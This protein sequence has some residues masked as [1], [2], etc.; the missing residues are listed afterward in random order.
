MLDFEMETFHQLSQFSWVETE[1]LSQ[2]HL[3]SVLLTFLKQLKGKKRNDV[4]LKK[5]F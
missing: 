3:M 2:L 4:F 5:K 1:R